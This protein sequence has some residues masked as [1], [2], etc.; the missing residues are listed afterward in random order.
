MDACR[1]GDPGTARAFRVGDPGIARSFFAAIRKKPKS[2]TF[3]AEF[4]AEFCATLNFDRRKSNTPGGIRTHNLRLR[5]PTRYP[6]V[7]RAPSQLALRI[8]T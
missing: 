4:C 3:E 5:R 8:V 6:I 7:P 1:V 2:G